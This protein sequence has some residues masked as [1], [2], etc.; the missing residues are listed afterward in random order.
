MTIIKNIASQRYFILIGYQKN[1]QL[2]CINP[3][4]NILIVNSNL[5][6][7]EIDID[8]HIAIAQNM[9][10]HNQ[11]EKFNEFNI[12]FAKKKRD[13]FINKIKNDFKPYI[14]S[15]TLNDLISILE[16]D[17]L[18]ELFS[19]NLNLREILDIAINDNKID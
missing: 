14:P 7:E 2:L 12:F 4:S 16:D 1:N 18:L 13:E 11:L 17:K 10:S 5:F 19:R 9:I 8:Q 6:E 3:E 15:D